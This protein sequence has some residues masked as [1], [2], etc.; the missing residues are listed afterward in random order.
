MAMAPP[1]IVVQQVL[2]QFFNQ[3]YSGLRPTLM[4]ETKENGAI[5][6]SSSIVLEQI[7]NAPNKKETRK[8][9]QKRKSGHASRQRRQAARA[10]KKQKQDSVSTQTQE[11][12]DCTVPLVCSLDQLQSRVNTAVQAVRETADAACDVKPPAL[13]ARKPNLSIIKNAAV[14]IPPRRIYHPA[15]HNIARTMFNKHPDELSEEEIEKFNSYCEWKREN[16]EPIET[17]VIHLPSSMRDCLHCGHP[18]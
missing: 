4:L 7:S 9:N 8:H 10:E 2:C 13:P 5:V 6:V 12:P 16:G 11:I 18:T 14:S 3:W 1:P 17:D 15:I